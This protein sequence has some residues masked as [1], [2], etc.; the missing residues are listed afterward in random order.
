MQMVIERAAEVTD[1]LFLAIRS[2]VPQLGPG[3]SAPT[4]L[5]LESLIRSDSSI[6]LLA[7][8]A[9]KNNPIAGILTLAIY[10]VPTGI[11]SIVEDVIV[12]E[13]FRRLGIAE[14]LLKK[15]VEIARDSGA[16]NVSLSANPAREAAHQLYQKLGFIRRDSFFYIHY[17]K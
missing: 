2:L 10:R 6:L 16:G 9:G 7:R 1:E 4:R 13:K 8:P 14:A 5:E 15:A 12:D 3:K 17:L 11:R